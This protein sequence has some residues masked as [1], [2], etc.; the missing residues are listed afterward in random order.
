MRYFKTIII[1]STIIGFLLFSCAKEI[2]NVA[3]TN[4]EV[5]KLA[6]VQVF[7]GIQKSAKNLIYMD[8][9][10]LSGAIIGLAGVY[11][12]STYAMGIT[13]GNRTFLVKDTTSTTTQVPFTFTENLEAGKSYTIFTYDT[14][15]TPKKITVV[16]NI[17]IPTDTTCRLRVANFFYNANSIP[18]VDVYSYRKGMTGGP[19]FANVATNTITDFVP[20]NSRISDTLYVY[21]TGTTTPLIFKYAVPS[22]TAQRGYTAAFSGSYAGTSK[23]LSVFSTY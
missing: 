23:F 14:I 13:E 18:N 5:N 1:T 22:L 6:L 2:P 12:T 11:P 7:D 4:S 10:H 9:N 21:K 8:G 15:T 16:N 3:K 19:L 20:F 17:V